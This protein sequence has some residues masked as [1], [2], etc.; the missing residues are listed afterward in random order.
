MGTTD[1]N[2]IDYPI[3]PPILPLTLMVFWG[4]RNECRNIYGFSF[5]VI[6]STIF[7]SIKPKILLLYFS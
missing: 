7:P 1:T 5:K 3:V 4:S 6:K 2:E